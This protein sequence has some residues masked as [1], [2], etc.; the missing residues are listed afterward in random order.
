MEQSKFAL[1]PESPEQRLKL[2]LVRLTIG[3]RRKILLSSVKARSHS[4]FCSDNL[5]DL[6][7]VI[8]SFL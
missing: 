4:A 7:V 8:T 1:L 6:N 5:S 3:L 2:S